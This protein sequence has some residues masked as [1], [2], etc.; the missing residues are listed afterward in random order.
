[1]ITISEE[2]VSVRT[3]PGS[4]TACGKAYRLVSSP[5][6]GCI[7]EIFLR[8]NVEGQCI[9]I[10]LQRGTHR[11]IMYGDMYVEVDLEILVKEKK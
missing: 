6:H 4:R 3:L 9:M 2:K 7:G 1:M 10:H 8:A 5:L 11:D